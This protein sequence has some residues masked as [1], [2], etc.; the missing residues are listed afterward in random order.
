MMYWF[1]T[2][3]KG[4]KCLRCFPPT[5]E[6]RRAEDKKDEVLRAESHRDDVFPS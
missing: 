2:V 6:K 3:L 5:E 4:T 1:Q